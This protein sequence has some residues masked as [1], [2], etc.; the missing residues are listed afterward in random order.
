MSRDSV[1]I[2]LL[3]KHT[4]IDK[5]FIDIFFKQFK[6]GGELDFDIEDKKIAKYFGIKIKTLRTRLQ[7]GYARKQMYIEGIDYK[8]IK[9][10]NTSGVKYMVNYKCFEN[11]AMMGETEESNA[12]REYFIKL[13]EFIRDN[14][15]LIYQAIENKKKL[16]KYS[17]LDSIYFFAAKKKSNIFKIGKS[18]NIIARLSNYNT[19]RIEDVDP[20]LLKRVV[21]KCYKD[22]ISKKDNQQLYREIADL[23]GMYIYTKNNPKVKP[24]VVIGKNIN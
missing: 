18:K 23:L 9:H 6:I 21:Y 14:Q 10:G 22:N 11:L 12:V 2:K 1:F 7:N 20:K 3:K 5:E 4:N 15:H 8:K 19:G 17:G 16:H 13:R 24:Y